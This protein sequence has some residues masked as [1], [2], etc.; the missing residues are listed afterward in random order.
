MK[1]VT[2]HEIARA[3]KIDSSTVSRALNNSDRVKESTKKL[4]LK[5]AEELGYRRNVLASNLRK[6]KGNTIGV[7]IPRVSRHFFSSAIAGIEKVAQEAGFNVIISQSLEQFDR[8][9]RIVENL[10]S[11][12]VD[13]ILI[14]VSMETKKAD[15]LAN[16]IKNGIPFVFFDRHLEGFPESGR[17]IIDDNFGG[18]TATEHLINK[19][20]KRI[21]HF[22]GP[23]DLHVYKNRLEGYKKALA[24]HNLAYSSDTPS[25][26]T[27]ADGTLLAKKILKDFKD[28]DGAFFANDIS[29]IAAM[30]YLK[31]AGIRIPED[32]AIVGFSNEPMSEVIEPSLTT[33]DQSGEIIGK[34]ACELLIDNI[35]KGNRVFNNE[36]VVFEP[37]LIERDSTKK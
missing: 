22:S 7:V 24:K 33:I 30:K 14:S 18:F 2:I 1:N 37:K 31:K 34:K 16:C 6:R 3:L 5:K 4:I 35:A 23:Q 21:A 8:E 12:R 17:V 28:I 20:C 9:E 15:H 25:R 27:E 11:N 26:L 10:I 13:G 36:A 32:I 19:G 29:A